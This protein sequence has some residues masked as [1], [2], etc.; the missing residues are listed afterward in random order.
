M[1]LV[2]KSNCRRPYAL[3]KPTPV[4]WITTCRS[5]PLYDI[6]IAK[7]R[8]KIIGTICRR[9]EWFACAAHNKKIKCVFAARPC[10]GQGRD[11]VTCRWDTWDESGTP[12]RRL[13]AVE[14]WGRCG[15]ARGARWIERWKST[16]YK[17]STA[18]RQIVGAAPKN[19]KKSDPLLH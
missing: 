3:I 2:C 14:Q 11:R 15:R 5:H 4:I 16:R 19:G 9:R 13:R 1:T 10:S 8:R 17:T 12:G 18:R 6:H 7:T